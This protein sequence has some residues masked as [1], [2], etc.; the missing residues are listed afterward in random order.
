MSTNMDKTT[1]KPTDN[2]PKEV[3]FTPNVQEIPSDARELLETY[4]KFPSNE[5]CSRTSKFQFTIQN[6]MTSHHLTPLIQ[7]HKAFKM[8]PYTCI[9]QF[10]FLSLNLRSHLLYH[11]LLSHLQTK[12]SKI[13]DI[14][15]CFGQDIRQLVI[16]RV[17]A[18][19]I[20]GIDVELKF[21]DLVESWIE[22]TSHQSH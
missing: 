6:Q 18:E 13:L 15:C 22:E 21:I 11:L 2:N 14:G 12:N 3:W 8:F 4:G 10:R 17:P 19:N 16:D 1:E 20:Y 7:R 9:G 5:V